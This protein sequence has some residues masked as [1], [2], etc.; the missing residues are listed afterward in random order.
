[1]KRKITWMVVFFVV[2]SLGCATTGNQTRDDL[3]KVESGLEVSYWTVYSAGKALDLPKLASGGPNPAMVFETGIK[4]VLIPLALM[5]K[6]R[7]AGKGKGSV[8]TPRT[9]NNLPEGQF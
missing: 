7:K 6:S 9:D 1:M 5:T 2:F 4:A 8:N 3:K